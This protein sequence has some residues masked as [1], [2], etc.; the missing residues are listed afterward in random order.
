MNTRAQYRKISKGRGGRGVGDRKTPR[1]M[2]KNT[3]SHE[4]ENK[5]E[6]CNTKHTANVI[7]QTQ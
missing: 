1:K 7:T 4:K 2:S 3:D 6:K 5:K